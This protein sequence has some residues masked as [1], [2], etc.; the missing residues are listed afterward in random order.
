MF[1]QKRLNFTNSYLELWMSKF[2]N[3]DTVMKLV[4]VGLY[5]TFAFTET[6]VRGDENDG[7]RW[8]PR[9]NLFYYADCDYTRQKQAVFGGYNLPCD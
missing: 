6:M 7:Q 2:D 3:E 4:K 1:R 5:F 8:R 9:V